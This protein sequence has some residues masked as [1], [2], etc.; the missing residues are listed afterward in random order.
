MIVIIVIIEGEKAGTD[1]EEGR[2]SLVTRTRLRIGERLIFA[3]IMV[4]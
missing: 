3:I 4:L 1:Y 2:P